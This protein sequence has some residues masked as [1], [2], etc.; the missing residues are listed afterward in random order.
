MT[1]RRAVVDA[2]VWIDLHAANLM[3]AVFHMPFQW[4][5]P[6]F[7][8]EEL[9]S[10]ASQELLSRGMIEEH[11]SGTEVAALIELCERYPRPGRRDLSA[12]ILADRLDCVLL[13]GDSAL[14]KAAKTEG[15][16]VHGT[17]WLL[18]RM[19]EAGCISP[20]RAADALDQMLDSGTHLPPSLCRRFQKR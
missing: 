11:F 7:I 8:V 15:I 13:T 3:D 14:R 19:V 16:E 9:R 2:S 20:A 18:Q 10:P 17:L 6:D 12:L 4:H 5:C 1:S